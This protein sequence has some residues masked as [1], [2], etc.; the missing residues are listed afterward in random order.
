MKLGSLKPYIIL[1]VM[2]VT[3]SAFSILYSAKMIS[4]SNHQFC[5][6]LVIRSEELVLKPL[7][8]KKDK[9]AELLYQRHLAYIELAKN[10][11]CIR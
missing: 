1:F 3:F 8:P 10:F 7:N 11:N 2:S 5:S 6:V 9:A 4:Q